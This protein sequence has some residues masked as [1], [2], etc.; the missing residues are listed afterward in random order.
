MT[1]EMIE[2]LQ[3][4]SDKETFKVSEIVENLVRKGGGKA[5][6]YVDQVEFDMTAYEAL[7][8]V[9]IHA[10]IPDG[11]D[12]PFTDPSNSDLQDHLIGDNHEYEINLSIWEE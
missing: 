5:L 8:E 3:E 1:T 10:I 6:Y 12:S 4:V 2:N 9:A 11:W 7:T